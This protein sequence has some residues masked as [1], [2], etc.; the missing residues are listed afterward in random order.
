MQK[1]QH[2]EINLNTNKKSAVIGEAASREGD[3]EVLFKKTSMRFPGKESHL[4]AALRDKRGM[5]PLKKYKLKLKSNKSKKVKK[6]PKKKKS[7]KNRKMQE[8]LDQ[9]DKASKDRLYIFLNILENLI[10]KTVQLFQN[11][12]TLLLNSNNSFQYSKKWQ[13]IP[14]KIILN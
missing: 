10:C 2:N 6:K 8:S 4:N 5:T 11:V 13:C 1:E 7:R 12:L 14:N 9:L 3:K